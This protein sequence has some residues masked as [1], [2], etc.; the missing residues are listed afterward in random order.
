MRLDP[1]KLEVEMPGS[2]TPTRAALTRALMAATGRTRL[3]VANQLTAA[4]RGKVNGDGRRVVASAELA[5]QCA[6]VMGVPVERLVS[7]GEEWDAS[8]ER[9]IAWRAAGMRRA[10]VG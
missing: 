9:L 7:D 3:A 4:L 8:V 2:A 6:A 1:W 5:A 10:V